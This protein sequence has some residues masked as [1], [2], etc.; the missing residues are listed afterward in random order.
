MDDTGP[1][2]GSKQD[3]LPLKGRFG[4]AVTTKL[5]NPLANSSGKVQDIFE[6][7]C[8]RRSTFLGCRD[9]LSFLVCCSDSGLSLWMVTPC[10]KWPEMALSNTETT[11]VEKFVMT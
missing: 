1:L 5:L 2:I 3:R 11:A 8:Q 6:R 7:D 10:A 4:T 9:R